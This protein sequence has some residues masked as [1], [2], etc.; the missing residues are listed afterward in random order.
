MTRYGELGLFS[1]FLD[2]RNVGTRFTELT[3]ESQLSLQK[4]GGDC[5]SRFLCLPLVC[6]VSVLHILCLWWLNLS[7]KWK[8][9]HWVQGFV[10][11]CFCLV[12]DSSTQHSATWAP[13]R[14]GV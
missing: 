3:V 4:V 9:T 5:F 10:T 6:A 14:F 1:P 11:S 2:Q 12:F 7:S 8:S 13:P